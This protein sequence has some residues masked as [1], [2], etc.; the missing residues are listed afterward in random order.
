MPVQDDQE[1]T[2][3]GDVRIGAPIDVQAVDE[4]RMIVLFQVFK[5]LLEVESN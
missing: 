5:V 1:D 2:D 4:R 3:A